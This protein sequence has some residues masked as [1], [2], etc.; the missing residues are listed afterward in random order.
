VEDITA[1]KE[2]EDKLRFQAQ[3]LDSV[4]EA[5]IATS[6]DGAVIYMNRYAESLYGW[7][8][9]EAIGQNIVELL[10]PDGP[11]RAAAE[12]HME[13]LPAADKSGGELLLRRRDGTTFPA[14]TSATPMFGADGGVEAFIGVSNDITEQKRV[15]ERLLRSH[16]ELRAL[17]GRVQKSIEEERARISREIHDELGQL[18]T[19]LK[20]DL[21]W[22][23]NRLENA[24]DAT[25]QPIVDR[26][27]AGSELTDAVIK[28]VQSIAADLRPGVL[29]KLG[30]PA[31]LDFEARR[32]QERNGILCTVQHPSDMSPLSPDV[33]TA[34][35]RIAQ[36]SLTNAARHSGATRVEVLLQET[37][38]D[39]VHLRVTDNGRGIKE[40]DPVGEK[41]LGLLG[42]R[43]RVNL[44]GGKMC[45][46]SCGGPGM[47]VDVVLPRNAI[48]R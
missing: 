44:L 37:A 45:L 13:T 5:V 21:R 36:E 22:I 47:T 15:R 14:V 2:A 18:L 4:G 42:I 17:T 24:G 7:P 8:K 23:K 10:M 20:M 12:K 6:A 1:R 48:I 33:T 38:D 41:S 40:D 31:A 29:D 27:V 35:F 25:L 9:E 39:A 16:G 32:F 34:L 11:D 46:G 26:V 3:M 43:E 28:A 19:G 30:L